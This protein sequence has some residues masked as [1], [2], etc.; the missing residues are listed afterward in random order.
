MSVINR[1]IVLKLNAAW[2]AV[3]VSTVAKAI[4]DLSAGQ[5]A[6]ALDFEYEK[7]EAGN[8]ILDEHGMPAGEPYPRAVDWATWINLSVRSWEMDDAIHYGHEGQKLM[9]APTVLIA[10]NYYKMPRKSFKG[11]PSKDAIFLRDNGVDQYTGKKLKRDEAT[12]DHILPK[13]KGG[14]DEWENL[15]LTSK[16]I[17][18]RKG[19]RLNHEI[20]LKLIRQPKAP[21]SMTA[22]EL[23]RD[24]KHPTWKPHLPHLAEANSQNQVPA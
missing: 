6:M 23:I 24:I 20:G 2:Q 16:D 22:M 11:K 18:S 1:T 21:K 14:R 12:I 15:A 4:V 7:D 3:G 10:K 8:Y 13:S 17:N 9:R 19:N 5:S